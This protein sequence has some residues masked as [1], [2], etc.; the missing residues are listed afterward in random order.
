M[1]LSGPLVVLDGDACADVTAHL[2]EAIRLNR[3]RG[4][5][6]PRALRELSDQVSRAA[7]S[8]A[9]FRASAQV[10]PCRGTAGFRAKASLPL[11]DQPVRLNI[12]EAAQL[13]R[14]SESYM[15][16]CCRRGAGVAGAPWV[17]RG[18][19]LA[20]GLDQPAPEGDRRVAGRL[21]T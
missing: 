8:S 15:R 7:R 2:V 11:S 9:G 14:V 21:S 17:G 20:S 6:P 18:H 19:R 1:Q 12:K 3:A 13:A 16:R 5:E 10:T 4:A